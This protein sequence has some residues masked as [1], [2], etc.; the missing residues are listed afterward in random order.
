MPTL[1]RQDGFEIRM[2]F[3]DHEP[4]HVHAFKV[5]GQAK[6]Q[7]GSLEVPPS[8]TLVQEMSAR[9]AKKAIEIVIEHQIKLLQKWGELHG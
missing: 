1:L 3:D 8:L 5:G 7:I 4:P 9:D 2:Y 6:I